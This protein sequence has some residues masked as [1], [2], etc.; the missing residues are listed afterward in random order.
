M[1]LQDI[2]SMPTPNGCAMHAEWTR[3]A[4]LLLK[5]SVR[6]TPLPWSAGNQKTGWPPQS[7]S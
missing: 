5:Q 7:E 4:V 3:N 1:S 6:Q 2:A